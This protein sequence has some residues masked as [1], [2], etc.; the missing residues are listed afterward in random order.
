[1][2]VV[3]VRFLITPLYKLDISQLQISIVGKKSFIPQMILYCGLEEK[4]INKLK[5][6][7]Y[8]SKMFT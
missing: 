4:N 5:K 1:M 8:F 3:M 7:K 6:I 2:Y